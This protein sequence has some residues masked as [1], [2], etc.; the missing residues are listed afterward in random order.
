[1][2]WCVVSLYAVAT[3]TGFAQAQSA[4][5]D[6][7]VPLAAVT[8]AVPA[9]DWPPG[10]KAFLWDG[11]MPATPQNNVQVTLNV[12]GASRNAANSNDGSA[13]KPFK[14]IHAALQVALANKKKTSAREYSF[15]QEFTVRPHLMSRD[16]AV[17]IMIHPLL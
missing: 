7:L 8:E 17:L 14:T 4:P 5:T 1:M 11:V 3:V 9:N 15:S 10:G 16:S 6:A 12:N 2:P 13:T